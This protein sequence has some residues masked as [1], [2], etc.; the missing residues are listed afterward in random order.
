MTHDDAAH[1]LTQ[2]ASSATSI[3]LRVNVEHWLKF[4]SYDK[5]GDACSQGCHPRQP[6]E[7]AWPARVAPMCSRG[8]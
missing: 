3:H 2:P 5:L 1:S 8:C 4:G 6:A 7:L